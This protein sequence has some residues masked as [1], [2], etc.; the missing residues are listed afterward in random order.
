MLYQKLLILG[1]ILIFSACQK[2]KEFPY[3]LE[4]PSKYNDSGAYNPSHEDN[5]IFVPHKIFTYSL[6]YF[7]KENTSKQ[8]C[9]IYENSLKSNWTWELSEQTTKENQHPITAVNIKVKENDCGATLFSNDNQTVIIYEYS[10]EKGVLIP[11]LEVSGIKENKKFIYIHP[12]RK[13]GLV[14]TEFT[15]FP[16]VELPLEIGKT[17]E[18]SGY[19]DN[20]WANAAGVQ[21]KNNADQIS[22]YK[23]YKVTG[24]EEIDSHFGKIEVFNIFAELE[25]GGLTNKTTL[26]MKYDNERGFIMLDFYNIDGSRIVM[27]LINIKQQS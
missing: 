3:S 1:V 19:I 24:K 11:E 18:S 22:T 9:I 7:D 27:E 15:P 26:K 10:N 23:S 17:W 2:G 14:I 20:T 13:N 8:L 25:S 6:Q 4:Y 21:Y 5:T 16:Y 12:P